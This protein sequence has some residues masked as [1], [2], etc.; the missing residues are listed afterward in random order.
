M[1]ESLDICCLTRTC[2]RVKWRRGLCPSCY[3]KAKVAVRTK[4]T[5]WERLI[6]EGKALPS[7]IMNRYTLFNPSCLKR[8][9]AKEGTMIKPYAYHKPSEVGLKKITALRE[10]FSTLHT[11]ILD[12]AP[13]SREKSVALTNLETAAMWGIK[14][15]VTNDPLTE[16]DL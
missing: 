4:Q 5:T 12:L 6:E 7:A 16:I 11:L 9:P 2:G 10:A 3:E 14:S 15:I 8:S 1:S 13:D